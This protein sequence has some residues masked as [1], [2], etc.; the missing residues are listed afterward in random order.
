MGS[1]PYPDIDNNP[2][3]T[4]LY[5]ITGFFSRFFSEKIGDYCDS[6]TFI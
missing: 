1:A 4:G 2:R 6:L 3:K 5:Q